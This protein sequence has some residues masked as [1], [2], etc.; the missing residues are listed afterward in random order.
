MWPFDW[1]HELLSNEQ[2]NTSADEKTNENSNSSEKQAHEEPIAASS[3]PKQE[4]VTEKSPPVS[5]E[6]VES[7]K[8]QGTP[9]SSSPKSEEIIELSDKPKPTASLNT[10]GIKSSL[11]SL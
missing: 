10:K 6:K 7:A 2:P 1:G 11:D 8:V 5:P 9:E 4:I 3:P